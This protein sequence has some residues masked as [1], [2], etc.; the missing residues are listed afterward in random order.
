VSKKTLTP[1]RR[2]FEEHLLPLLNVLWVERSVHR[3]AVERLLRTD[4]RE[5]SLVDCSSF[6]LMYAGGIRQALALDDDFE[7]EGYRLLPRR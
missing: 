3:A 7:K 4:R 2:D 6:E 5:L 1:R